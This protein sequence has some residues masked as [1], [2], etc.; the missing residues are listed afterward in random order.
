MKSRFG[1]ALEAGRLCQAERKTGE[2]KEHFK[3]AAE[4]IEETGYHRRD[5]EVEQWG[6]AY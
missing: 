4:M 2:A 6:R 5:K 3:K 1:E